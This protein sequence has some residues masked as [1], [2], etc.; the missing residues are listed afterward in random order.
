M[1][2]VKEMSEGLI[3]SSALESVITDNTL[4]DAPIGTRVFLVEHH[5]KQ[6][7]TRKK[8]VR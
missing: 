4:R 1:V 3:I 5:K 6:V 8:R 7:K 2:V